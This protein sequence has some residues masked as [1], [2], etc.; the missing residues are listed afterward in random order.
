MKKLYAIVFVLVAFVVLS[1]E[2]FSVSAVNDIRD[3]EKTLTVYFYTQVNGVDTPIPGAEIGISKI[4][5]M[6]INA[7]DVTYTVTDKYRDF[8]DRSLNN[9]MTVD[10]SKA[11]ANKFSEFADVDFVGITDSDGHCTFHISASGIYLI[12]QLSS[13]GTAEYY[14]FFEPYILSVPFFSEVDSNWVYDILS[15][16]KTTKIVESE[17]SVTESSYNI[18][19]S[20][21][22]NSDSG[23]SVLTGDSS[24]SFVLLFGCLLCAS[25][26]MFILCMAKKER[27]ADD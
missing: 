24:K 5:D 2:P 1:L 25:V 10:E 20:S 21:S 12:R 13:S 22:G 15:E 27:K 16:P 11:V 26:A 18:D 4:A 17:P 9:N 19:E 8:Y 14:N 3:G 7:D 23:D 6:R